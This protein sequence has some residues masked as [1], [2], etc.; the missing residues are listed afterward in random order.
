MLS[1]ASLSDFLLCYVISYFD[2]KVMSFYAILVDGALFHSIP[3]WILRNFMFF[4]CYF[5]Q[6]GSKAGAHKNS[7]K[8]SPT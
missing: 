1:Y 8:I 6:I 5:D 3:I 4:E 7:L 2:V